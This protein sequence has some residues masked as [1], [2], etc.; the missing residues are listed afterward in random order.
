[1]TQTPK[2]LSALLAE[3]PDNTT[4]DIS[5]EDIRD[6]VVSLFPSRDRLI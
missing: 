1:M 3:L 5:P 6:V 4:G 2:I